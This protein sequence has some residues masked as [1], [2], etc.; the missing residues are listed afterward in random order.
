MGGAS[1]NGTALLLS[2]ADIGNN[3]LAFGGVAGGAA[4]PGCIVITS[5]NAGA[6]T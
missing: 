4:S 3:L 6:T 1:A 2:G 5:A